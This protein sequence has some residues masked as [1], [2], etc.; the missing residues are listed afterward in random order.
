M[1]RKTVCKKVKKNYI[2]LNREIIFISK[3][4]H[5]NFQ[6]EVGVKYFDLN[7]VE[8]FVNGIYEYLMLEE[9]VQKLLILLN[10]INFDVTFITEVKLNDVEKMCKINKKT[11]NHDL[12]V[13]F[14]GK[15][16]VTVMDPTYW[17]DDYHIFSIYDERIHRDYKLLK[18]STIGFMIVFFKHVNFTL[19]YYEIFNKKE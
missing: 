2:I 3:F 17:K 8:T 19:K 13:M 1:I 15:S 18:G 11:L 5:L 16:V 4:H 14:M 9:S 10:E 12:H 6:T 7:Q